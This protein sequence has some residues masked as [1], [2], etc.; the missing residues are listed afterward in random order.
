[1]SNHIENL[2]DEL[3]AANAEMASLQDGIYDLL[4]YLASDKF[5]VDNKVTNADVMRRLSET[6]V[7]SRDDRDAALLNERGPKPVAS[8]KGWA[9][10]ICG[11]VLQDSPIWNDTDAKAERRMRDHWTAN[12][13]AH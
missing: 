6:L 11:S 4:G 2:S 10:P 9:C 8:F 7:R 13:K 3:V 12:H 1:M 5:S